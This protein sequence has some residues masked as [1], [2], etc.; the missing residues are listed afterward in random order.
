MRAGAHIGVL[1]VLEENNIHIDMVA[2]TSAG[3]AVAALY[4]WGC[5][6]QTMKDLFLHLDLPALIGARP[7]MTGLLIPEGYLRII[8][9]QTND[10]NIEDARIPLFIVAADLVSKKQFVFQKGNIATAVHASSALPGLIKPVKQDDMLLID[11][12]ILN[13]CPGNI[14]RENGADIVLAVNCSCM[15]PYKPKNHVDVLFRAMDMIGDCD[16]GRIDGDWVI[17]PI[18][19]PMGILERKAIEKSYLLGKECANAHIDE[20][21]EILRK[22]YGD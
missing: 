17:S 19:R 1:E 9:T 21:K 13:N 8:R 11:G 22:Y 2:G 16:P 10:G 20:L 14:L 6:S 15:A 12:G 7:S 18:N 3:A 5:N 4:A